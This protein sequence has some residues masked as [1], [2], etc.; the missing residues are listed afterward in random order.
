MNRRDFIKKNLQAVACLSTG[1]A[2]ANSGIFSIKEA[3]ATQSG[4]NKKNDGKIKIGILLFDDV[5]VLDFAG[6]FEVFSI[7]FIGDYSNKIF[8][9]ITVSE[10]GEKIVATNGLK[11]I[12]DYS[13]TDMPKVDVLIIPGGGDTSAIIKNNTIMNWIKERAKE[14]EI[15][16]SVCTGAF[17]LAKAGLLEGREVTTHIELL[18]TL[19]KEYPSCTVIRDV[20]FVDEDDII[21]SAGISAGIEMSFHLVEKLA[22][23]DVAKATAGIMQYDIVLD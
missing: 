10:D 21:T 5:E 11:V 8:D 3:H 4:L 22:G 19:E 9:V 14:V 18:D 15:T 13:I 6:P 12:P 23:L 17:I 20:K 16:A 2:L 1:V 7:P